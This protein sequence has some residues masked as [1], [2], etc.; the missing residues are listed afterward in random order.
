MPSRL[1]NKVTIITG[2]ANGIGKVAAELFAREGAKV[3]ITDIDP[4]GKQWAEALQAEGLETFW[5]PCDVSDEESV[6]ALIT[7]TVAHY[8]RLDV[9][10]NN[11]GVESGDGNLTQLTVD[12]WQRLT[13]TNA[14]GVFLMCKHAVP[15]MLTS[16]G[17]SVRFRS[18]CS[19]R[20]S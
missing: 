19:N 20:F 4:A 10:Y 8:G 2:A 11:A 14:R 16:G 12:D 13:D 7:A 15:A 3:V 1:A 9:L 6:K 17:G 18:Y 5:H